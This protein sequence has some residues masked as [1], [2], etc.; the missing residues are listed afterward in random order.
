[1]GLK[2]QQRRTQVPAYVIVRAEVSDRDRFKEY[3]KETPQ[4]IALH[5]G[6]YIAR[7]GEVVVLEGDAQ[8]KRIM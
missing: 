3:L 7:G 4:T 1:M 2:T 8:G 5:G 6:K